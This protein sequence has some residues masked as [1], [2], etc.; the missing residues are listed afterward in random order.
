MKSYQKGAFI[1]AIAKEQLRQII[2]ESELKSV[3]DVY[4][5]LKE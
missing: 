3:G 2:R 5:L 4:T 1:I